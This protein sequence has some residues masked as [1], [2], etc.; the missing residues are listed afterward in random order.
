MENLPGAPSKI[1]YI[2]AIWFL[3][4]LFWAETEVFIILKIKT[5]DVYK[6][7]LFVVINLI[8]VFGGRT[9]LLPTNINTGLAA[10]TFV[11]LGHIIR[12]NELVKRLQSKKSFLISLILWAICVYCYWKLRQPFYMAYLEYPLYGLDVISGMAG[13]FVFIE[14][15]KIIS[16]SNFKSINRLIKMVGKN[17]LFIMCVHLFDLDCFGFFMENRPLLLIFRIVFD[18]FIGITIGNMVKR[19]KGNAQKKAWRC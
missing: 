5:K 10:G 16:K 17:T 2:G 14:L 13:T 9:F 18:L 12:K 3:Q 19:Y 4:A 8:A 7:F 15:S 1:Q 11:F 6:L